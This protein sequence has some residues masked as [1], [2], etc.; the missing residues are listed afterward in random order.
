M[1]FPDSRWC[2]CR[3]AR[4]A[5]RQRLCRACV[6]VRRHDCR[7]RRSARRLIHSARRSGKV[8]GRDLA[9]DRSRRRRALCLVARP[10]GETVIR[11]AEHELR[12]AAARPLR[13]QSPMMGKLG[14]CILGTFRED[15]LG[16][17]HVAE[18]SAARLARRSAPRRRQV[19]DV[20]RASR[21]RNRPRAP[22]ARGRPGARTRAPSSSRGGSFM[23]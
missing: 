14:E 18:T 20:P 5:N 22:R 13:P 1:P 3:A 16:L 15:C 8:S 11:S 17:P 21:S 12:L 23:A 6:G 2:A 4:R 19:R 7:S 9:P 10:N